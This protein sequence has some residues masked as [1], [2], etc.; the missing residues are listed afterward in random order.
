MGQFLG[1]QR[2][3]AFTI[4]GFPYDNFH[5]DVVKH[6]V[7]LPPWWDEKR[8][9]YT[10]RLASVLAA[11][12]PES[13]HVGSI[14][15]LPIGWPS[16]P[17]D[18]MANRVLAPAQEQQQL[19]QAGANLRAAAKMLAKVES[20]TGKRIVLA[21]EPEPGCILDTSND[22]V[23]W[24]DEHLPESD[25]RRYITVCHDVCHA[26]VMM[27]TQQEVL[28]KF[29][30]N[31]I[32]VGKVQVSSAVVADWQ[33]MNETQRCEARTQLAE[34]AEDRYLHQTGRLTASGEFLL[35]EDLPDI[36]SQ[37]PGDDR[38][39]GC[40]FPCADFCRTIRT[41]DHQSRRCLA[42]SANYFGTPGL[43]GSEA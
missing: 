25:H 31:G 7:Y 22:L 19:Q 9:A 30:R 40:P 34:F 38:A 37:D 4:N 32:A 33:A 10:Q 5:Q 39:V 35:A 14:S 17:H 42:M 41:F 15:T 18:P 23:A 8:L 16:N 12:L 28:E 36:V 13:S 11:L 20:S 29:A 6:R 21:I 3:H 2:L 43:W 1:E 26:A 27:E 24:F